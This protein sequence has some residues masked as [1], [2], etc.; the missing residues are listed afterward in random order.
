MCLG[1]WVKKLIRVDRP[2][3]WQ[4][5]VLQQ[6]LGEQLNKVETDPI[7]PYREASVSNKLD[8]TLPLTHSPLEYVASMDL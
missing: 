8:W 2:G 6:A 4:E 7:I 1:N 3:E 5:A